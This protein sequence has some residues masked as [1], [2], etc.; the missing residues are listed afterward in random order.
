MNNKN[1]VMLTIFV[2]IMLQT[3]A[4]VGASI[5]DIQVP[6]TIINP[7]FLGQPLELVFQATYPASNQSFAIFELDYPQLSLSYLRYSALIGSNNITT[8][9]SLYDDGDIIYLSCDDMIPSDGALE[10]KITFNSIQEGYYSI[11]W[12][13]VIGVFTDL[14]S[15]PETIDESGESQIQI[16]SEVV[17]QFVVGWNLVGIP[18][19]IQ[20]PTITGLFQENLTKVS[21]I[22]GFD[23]TDKKFSYWI[24]GLP[25]TITSLECG[26]GYWVYATE[27]FTLTLTGDLGNMTAVTDGWNLIGVHTVYPVTPSD[28]LSGTGWSE[29]YGY[30][31][32]VWTYNYPVIGGTLTEMDPGKGYWIKTTPP[33]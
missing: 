33:P 19:D 10:V 5:T 13:H 26:K 24:N 9:F 6:A 2:T 22:Y 15:V 31:G 7:I 12:R 20:D 28:Y 1:V 29:V 11:Y 4:T 32:G 3:Q 25:S 18:F 30:E 23:N 21:Y 17:S 27:A 8:Q 16:I 14:I